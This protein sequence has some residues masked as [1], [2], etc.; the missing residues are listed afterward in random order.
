MNMAMKGSPSTATNLE[1]L[2]M[3]P[4]KGGERKMQ[5]QIEHLFCHI[6]KPESPQGFDTRR[7]SCSGRT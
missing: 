5:M 3:S 7:R 1:Y 4:M 6:Q 2:I